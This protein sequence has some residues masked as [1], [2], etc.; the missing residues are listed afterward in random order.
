MVRQF[1]ETLPNGVKH[2]ILK[3]RAF[4][5]AE[6]DKFGPVNIPKDHFFFLGDNRDL[7]QDCRFEQVGFVHQDQLV[8]RVEFLFFSTTAKWWQF[9]KFI[10]GLRFSRIFNKI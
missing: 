5:K 4:G 3:H 10:S 9:W 7:S 6:K 1:I 8:G 2:P